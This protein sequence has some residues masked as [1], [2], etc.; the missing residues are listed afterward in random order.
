MFLKNT[1]KQ[2][3]SVIVIPIFFFF[4]SCNSKL[5]PEKL[6]NNISENKISNKQTRKADKIKGSEIIEKQ[7]DIN[8]RS[9]IFF[10][11]NRKEYKAF[12]KSTGQYSKYEF[13]ELFRKFANTGKSVKQI[14]KNKDIDFKM[15]DCQIFNFKLDSG[16]VYKFNRVEEDK[17][18]GQIFFDGKNKPLIIDGMMKRK[19]IK[20]TIKEYFKLSEINE[21]SK[22]TL[23]IDTID[24]SKHDST[25]VYD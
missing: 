2:V 22:D 25:H 24:V 6:N 17:I 16:K 9:I 12:I 20:D 3:V 11:L 13:D 21:F 19:E 1:G 18:M 10:R 23:I 14:L 4:F 7:I 8:T 5:E 15:S